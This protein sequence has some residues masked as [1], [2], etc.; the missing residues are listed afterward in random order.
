MS[1]FIHKTKKEALFR[2]IVDGNIVNRFTCL[3]CGLSWMGNRR[4]DL[5]RVHDKTK[6]E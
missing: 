2:D 3:K 4:F 5:F 1:C 6:Q